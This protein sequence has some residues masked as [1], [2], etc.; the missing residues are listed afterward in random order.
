MKRS[1]VTVVPAVG[2]I[3]LALV[4]TACG[5]SIGGQA[6]AGSTASSSS[7]D[8]STSTTPTTTSTTRTT[9]SESTDETTTDETSTSDETSDETETS[10]ETTGSGGLDPDTTAWFN[11]FCQGV[12]DM[13]QYVSPDTSGQSLSEIQAT[14]VTTY[15]NISFSAAST[16]LSLSLST[17]PP[18]EG[19]QSLHDA[20]IARYSALS[21]VYSQ[22]ASTVAAMSPTSEAEL[23]SAVD[24][25]EQQASDSQTDLTAS[26]DP[27][28]LESAR[29]LPDC[30][31]VLN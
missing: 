16:A 1:L 29:Q 21:D 25:I 10:E 22:G 19:G 4:L 14:I 11:T 20:A 17:V 28:V 3:A 2:A 7:S 12:T 5:S 30:Q 23:K 8:T 18:I 6:Q 31:G 26:I 27:A 24:T 13:A 9:E 15:T